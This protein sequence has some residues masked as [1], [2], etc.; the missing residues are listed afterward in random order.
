MRTD[1]DEILHTAC[2][3]QSIDPTDAKLIHHYSN[4]VYILPAAGAVARINT[5]G[6]TASRLETTQ[7][8]TSWLVADQGFAA[9]A[10]LPGADLVQTDASTVVTFWIYYRQPV[11]APEL[12]STHL[13]EL[14]RTLHHTPPPPI[15]VSPWKPLES[16][17]NALADPAADDALSPNDRRWLMHRIEELETELGELEWPLGHGLI[18]GDAWAGNLLWSTDDPHRA[19]VCDWDRVSHGPLEVD[20]IPTWHAA[21]RYGRDEAWIQGFV[22]RYG[23]DLRD[24]IGY[25]ALLAMRDLAQLPGPIRRVSNP[26]YAAVLRQRLNAIRAGHRPETWVTAPTTRQGLLLGW[27]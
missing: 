24:S 22:K 27:C 26:S 4:A 15:E 25:E 10:P 1:L 2:S 21:F 19:M 8:I 3:Q 20:L 16:L 6:E 13:G 23:Y 5:G 17:Q 9:T 18:H 14:L 12:T 11:T 7:A